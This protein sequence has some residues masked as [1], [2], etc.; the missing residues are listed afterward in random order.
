M[1]QLKKWVAI[2]SAV[3]SSAVLALALTGL[4]GP[5]CGG[6]DSCQV[7]GEH[8]AEGYGLGS[9]SS[10]SGFDVG[11][12]ARGCA[13]TAASASSSSQDEHQAIVDGIA[14]ASTCQGITRCIGA[15]SS[16]YISS[17]F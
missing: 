17:A 5:G 12:C 1:R 11:E 14:H 7:A 10:S 15:P 2:A 13:E 8:I 3:L 4:V 6:G 16:S 9:S